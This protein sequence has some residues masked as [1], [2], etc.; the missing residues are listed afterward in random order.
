MSEETKKIVCPNCLGEAIKEGN[1]IICETCDAT[2]TFTKT[3]AAK[4]ENVGRLDS[5]EKRVDRIETFIPGQE[6]DSSDNDVPEEP[7]ILG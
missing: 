5:L 6:P 2:F 4:V 7:S 1:K 3:G